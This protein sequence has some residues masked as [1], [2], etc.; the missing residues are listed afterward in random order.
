MANNFPDQMSKTL[1]I[2]KQYNVNPE[3]RKYKC[4]HCAK[5]FSTTQALKSYHLLTFD[6]WHSMYYVEEVTTGF[7]C[8]HQWKYVA[9]SR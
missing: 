7:F 8:V 9:V 1:N 3:K 5:G 4:E 2:C 6:F